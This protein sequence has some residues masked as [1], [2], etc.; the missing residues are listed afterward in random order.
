MSALLDASF[1]YRK[2]CD[3]ELAPTLLS[4]DNANAI[5]HS[6]LRY[7]LL[8]G[9]WAGDLEATIAEAISSTKARVW[10]KGQPTRNI[11][12]SVTQ[13][14]GTLFTDEVLLS[15]ADDNALGEMNDLLDQGAYWDVM[16]DHHEQV[17]GI[18]EGAIVIIRTPEGPSFRALAA[19]QWNAGGTFARPGRPVWF[20]F[21]EK[22]DHRSQWEGKWLRHEYDMR[23]PRN[24]FY[25]VFIDNPS[26]VE[27]VTHEYARR[28]GVEYPEGGFVG[29]NYE[30]WTPDGK[31]FLPV[32]VQHARPKAKM[33]DAMYG[34]ELVAMTLDI[35]VLITMWYHGMKSASYPQKYG[36]D[37]TLPIE[38]DD[39]DDE[40]VSVDLDPAAILM[41]SSKAG[42]AG[43]LG[44]F[45]SAGD[46]AAFLGA[47]HSHAQDAATEF[48]I[49]PTDIS[50]THG[51]AQSGYAVQLTN[52]G[53][54]KQQRRYV[55][56]AR[57]ADKEVLRKL[58]WMYPERRLTPDGWSINY[59]AQALSPEEQAQIIENDRNLLEMGQLSPV[60]L[61]RKLNP[62]LKD[63]AAAEES[64]RQIQ[65]ER[66]EFQL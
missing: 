7:R 18:R 43:K 46:P 5:R 54:R 65:R 21:F 52:S 27:E 32:V 1:A 2:A 14:L 39:I 25:K 13:E 6:Y 55:K 4:G 49:S 38:R 20:H 33:R 17:V 8:D 41:F 59:T 10:G 34:S 35:G 63:H 50:R 31:P 56:G 23:D 24:P 12:K 64:L 19:H 61:H 36:L 9:M 16:E 58:A 15:H 22:S 51:N 66:R 37:V 44:A 57:R 28:L 62:G 60:Q 45:P 26:K 11:F 3:A 42:K 40:S 29:K 47:I 30:H 53:V 48:G